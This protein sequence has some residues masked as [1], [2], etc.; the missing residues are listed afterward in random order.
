PPDAAALFR[1]TAIGRH[2]AS[3]RDAV[4]AA[5]RERRFDGLPALAR[6]A[7]LHG[8]GLGL[9]PPRGVAGLDRVERFLA[10]LGR[11]LRSLEADDARAVAEG[12]GFQLGSVF[13]PYNP[14]LAA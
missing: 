3:R 11:F 10:H 9:E 7:L 6:E 1:W 5:A 4:T 12:Y 13:D 8:V 14:R 2:L